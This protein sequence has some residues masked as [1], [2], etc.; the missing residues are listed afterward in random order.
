MTITLYA[1][2]KLAT[3]KNFAVDDIETYLATFG[4]SDKYTEANLNY[5][6]H[7]LNTFILLDL[8]Q[9][10]LNYYNKRFNFCKIQNGTD[11]AVYYF[12][13]NLE[14]RS[15]QVIYLTLYQDTISTFGVLPLTSKCLVHREHK[16][17][18]KRNSSTSAYPIID[19][20]GEGLN[21]I[22]LKDSETIV[23][24]D[25][26]DNAISLLNV[27]WFIAYINNNAIDATDFNQVN[28]VSM[29][30]FAENDI[31]VSVGASTYVSLTASDGVVCYAPIPLKNGSGNRYIN[32][33]LNFDGTDVPINCHYDHVGGLAVNW[34]KVQRVGANYEVTTCHT[35]YNSSMTVI[36]SSSDTPVLYNTVLYT[37]ADSTARTFQYK[38]DSLDVYND[39]VYYGFD[40]SGLADNCN[41]LKSMDRTDS[42]IIKIVELPYCPLMI[43]GKFDPYGLF[44][45]NNVDTANT[46]ISGFRALKL[47]EGGN[48][49]ENLTSRYN[50]NHI[51]PYPSNFKVYSPR[52]WYKTDLKTKGLEFKLL[53]SELYNLKFT[54]DSFSKI[55][56]L[57]NVTFDSLFVNALTFTFVPSMNI[58]SKFLFD[59][60]ESFMTD[61]EEDYGNVLV[62]TRNNE[63]PIYTSQYINYLRTGYNYD[64]K[65]KEQKEAQNIIG[66]AL[67]LVGS[68]V[69]IIGGIASENP[70]LIG[71]SV[72]GAI[73]S[74]TSMTANTIYSSV[75]MTQAIEQKIAQAKAQAVSVQ[76]ADDLSLL[77]YYTKNNKAKLCYYKPSQQMENNLFNMFYYL[78]YRAEE[79]KKPNLSSRL[80]FNYI[81]ADIDIDFNAISTNTMNM[82]KEIIDD[83][84][85]RFAVGLTLFHYFNN[86]YDFEQKYE[87]YESIFE[88]DLQ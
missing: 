55:V 11:K 24:A 68:T 25:G 28:P 39:G 13:T 60:S 81:E 87:N 45:Y 5:F 44:F 9:S 83:Y 47:R 8:G 50:Y 29:W 16:D 33:T 12:I 32:Y 71:S 54:Y 65:A 30:I 73:T 63:A 70:F 1:N 72:V 26:T 62:V 69:G 51:K 37:V 57:E 49:F 46:P 10:A 66:G 78:G 21:P 88:N 67:G 42:K 79:M 82:T 23:S 18:F 80:R 19:K 52:T 77:D 40:E 34:A 86:E 20:V 74:V 58:S 31:R 75:S 7:K 61:K 3:D 41:G 35:T 85:G 36:S 38:C 43:Y 59:L 48:L 64:V 6:V 56:K 2:C 14:W 4:T 15:K 84:K 76:N 17:R 27:R 22:L 53:H